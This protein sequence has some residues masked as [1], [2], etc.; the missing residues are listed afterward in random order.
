[1]KQ[2]K[3]IEDSKFYFFFKSLYFLHYS[4]LKEN[5]K[6][7]IGFYLLRLT[8]IYFFCCVPTIC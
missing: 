2:N 5:R 7:E 3:S 8:D 1:M 6:Y 4:K